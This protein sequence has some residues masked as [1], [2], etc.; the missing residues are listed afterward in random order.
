[1][2]FPSPAVVFTNIICRYSPSLRQLHRRRYCSF[3]YLASLISNPWLN[4]WATSYDSLVYQI[5]WT[6]PRRLLANDIRG[7]TNLVHR[8]ELPSIF[9]QSKT[10]PLPF[11]TETAPNK[12]GLMRIQYV[13]RSKA[14]WMGKKRGQTCRRNYPSLRNRKRTDDCAMIQVYLKRWDNG[15]KGQCTSASHILHDGCIKR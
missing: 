14:S 15:I 11:A 3:H 4:A 8:L 10:I 2:N 5:E 13:R 12:Y 9:N 6:I 7:M 1:M